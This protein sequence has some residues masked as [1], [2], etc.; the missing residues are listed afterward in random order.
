MHPPRVTRAGISLA[1][2]AGSFWCLESI[3]P[4]LYA[5]VVN[6]AYLICLSFCRGVLGVTVLRRAH[7]IMTDAL[8]YITT[9]RCWLRATLEGAAKIDGVPASF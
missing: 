5:L 8:A 4:P 2:S 7:V 6:P 9:P 3:E 1:P